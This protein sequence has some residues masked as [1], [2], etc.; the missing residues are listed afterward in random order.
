MKKENDFRDDYILEISQGEIEQDVTVMAQEEEYPDNRVA[1]RKPVFD[2]LNEVLEA[3]VAIK[4]SQKK[5]LQVTQKHVDSSVTIEQMNELIS[6]N[7]KLE[8]EL[9]R[10]RKFVGSFSVGTQF[11]QFSL[12]AIC[13]SIII[14]LLIMVADGKLVFGMRFGVFLLAAT[15]SLFIISSFVPQDDKL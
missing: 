12:A 13:V 3:Q 6:L 15:I 7:K 4:D 1:N 8:Q 11:R 14:V 9:G 10:V 5:L 2:L